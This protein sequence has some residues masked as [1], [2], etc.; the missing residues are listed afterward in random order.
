M[1]GH[2]APQPWDH[3]AD[4]R[5]AVPDDAPHSDDE[6]DEP[7]D[8]EGYD[9]APVLPPGFIHRRKLTPDDAKAIWTAAQNHGSKGALITGQSLGY[10][11]SSVYKAINLGGEVPAKYRSPT[12]PKIWNNDQITALITHI[13]TNP[14]KTLDELLAWAKD[15]GFP[16]I[17]RSTLDGYLGLELITYKSVTNH[18]QQ[19][20]CPE[21]LDAR[22]D[23]AQWFLDHQDNTF[24]YLDEFGFNLSTQRHYGRARTGVPAIQITPANQG[25]NVSVAMAIQR[26]HGIVLYEVQHQAFKIPTFTAFV[27]RLLTQFAGTA[28]VCFVMDNCRIHD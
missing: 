8:G 7:S 28:D 2:R 6:V 25:T 3:R 22:A 13:E 15:Q 5:G 1:S 10:G 11:H 23:Y 24:V 4:L 27:A 17:S 26:G 12:R 16:D 9:P 19:R 18:N 21:N 14:T 20:N